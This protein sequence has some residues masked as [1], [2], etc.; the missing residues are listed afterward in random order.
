[1]GADAHRLWRRRLAG[2]PAPMD[3]GR[4]RLKAQSQG[5]AYDIGGDP[6]GHAG[7]K[8]KRRDSRFPAAREARGQR[9]GL[10]QGVFERGG[11]LP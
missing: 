9:P 7:T 2:I 3:G 5:A 8:S 11:G 1:M 4:R 6:D 10:G